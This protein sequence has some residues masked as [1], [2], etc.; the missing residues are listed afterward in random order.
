MNNLGKSLTYILFLV[1]DD[2]TFNFHLDKLYLGVRDALKIR[3][4]LIGGPG[5]PRMRKNIILVS[6]LSELLSFIR[7][8]TANHLA[9]LYPKDG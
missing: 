1:C 9:T 2:D 5:Q 4:Q 8:S 7:A 3:V 6:Y